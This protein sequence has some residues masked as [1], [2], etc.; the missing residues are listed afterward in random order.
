[1]SSRKWLSLIVIGMAATF[2]GI[3]RAEICNPSFDEASPDCSPNPGWQWVGMAGRYVVDN[4]GGAQPNGFALLREEDHSLSI[5]DPGRF[6]NG[7][8][9]VYQ[10]ITLPPSTQFISFKY[11]LFTSS[12][13]RN[14]A[15]PPDSF[16]AWLTDASGNR[17][18]PPSPSDAPDFTGA[19]LYDDSDGTRRYTL[20]FVSV[21]SPDEAGFRTVA[22][23]VEGLAGLGSDVFR[24][25]FGLSH[26]RN[27]V[28]SF[29]AIDDVRMGCPPGHC[30]GV[31]TIPVCNPVDIVIIMDTS[32]SMEDEIDEL[33]AGMAQIRDHGNGDQTIRVRIMIINGAGSEV[34]HLI[35]SCSTTDEI[36][37]TGP[38]NDL[39]TS[40]ATQVPLGIPSGEYTCSTSLTSGCSNNDRAE[41]WGPAAAV[42]AAN[43]GWLTGA[44]RVIIPISDEGPCMGSDPCNALSGD[45]C[46]PPSGT[47]AGQN[48]PTGCCLTDGS[49]IG[50]DDSAIRNASAVAL[51]QAP[52]IRI[53]P[54]IS[55]INHECEAAPC[56]RTLA[57]RIAVETGGLDLDYS[58]HTGGPID[59]ASAVIEI[60]NAACDCE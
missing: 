27:G 9:R 42:V 47:C 25:E 60:I 30:C 46:S 6:G 13:Q 41:N 14:A 36:T 34:S 35:S 16:S 18:V 44:T 23:K 45:S 22:V 37:L 52:A 2:A 55:P 32:G 24:L 58:N 20:P 10:D 11:R 51:A 12:G 48:N 43:Y 3:A 28:T 54:I 19:F 5:T 15:M 26:A 59:V 7:L 17:L 8:S 38:D 49:N 50:A 53:S 33:C 1:M 31:D 39:V 56:I 21:A 29:A 57:H 4:G 40:L